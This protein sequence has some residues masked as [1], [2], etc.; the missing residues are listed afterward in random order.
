MSVSVATA[1]DA[2]AIRGL[3]ESS[4]LPTGDLAHSR[5]EL[6]VAREGSRIVGVA[7]LE[8]FGAT[9]L[10]RSVVVAPDRRGLGIASAL[11]TNLEERAQQLGLSEL[12]L[13]TQTAK[14]FFEHQ[15]YRVIERQCA[16][17]SVQASEEFRS[18]CPTSAFCMAKDLDGLNASREAHG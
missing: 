3:L 6:V 17:A 4:G 13:L 16:P 1:S 10:L 12:V 18:L 5:P 8:R 11:V 7:G 14:D 9:G 15:G 2:Q